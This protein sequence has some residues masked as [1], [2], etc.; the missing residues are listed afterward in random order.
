MRKVFIVSIL[1]FCLFQC[2]F[3]EKPKIVIERSF[4]INEYWDRYNNGLLIERLIINDSLDISVRNIEV[5]SN[6]FSV[7]S[8]DS[9]F[10]AT[11]NEIPDFKP[12]DNPYNLPDKKLKF[13]QFN[14]GYWRL[15][16]S[17][18]KY[19]L[20]SKLEKETWYKFSK[21]P[22]V[23]GGEI[24]VYVNKEGK[25]INFYHEMGQGAW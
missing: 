20:I 18:T 6:D 5:I 9:S 1:T 19:K 3:Y 14:G 10:R 24:Y 16:Y 22:G 12:K 8:V 7:L 4:I 17:F 13:D 21:M 11:Y 2:V 25:T 15:D 23:F